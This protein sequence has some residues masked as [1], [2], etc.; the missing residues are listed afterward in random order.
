MGGFQK[1]KKPLTRV[2]K[3]VPGVHGERGLE[4]GWQKRSAKGWRKV[5]E[6][7][8][9]GWHRVGEGL[10]DFFAPSIAGVSRGNT[11]RGNTTR[12]S[13]RKMAL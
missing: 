1:P 11:I 12:N 7:L 6:G 9:K 13:E 5:G 10:A 2:S 4:R 8:A 3:R